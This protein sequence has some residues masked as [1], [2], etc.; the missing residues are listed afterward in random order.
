MSEEMKQV[1]NVAENLPQVDLMVA[2]F[3]AAIASVGGLV[4][5]LQKIVNGQKEFKP[6]TMMFWL[7]LLIEIFTSAFI[8]VLVYWFCSGYELSPYYIAGLA[9][10]AG[11]YGAT[12]FDLIGKVIMKRAGLKNG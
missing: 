3:Y 8:G 11:H 6:K 12:I 9:G 1:A 4:K 10:V 7:A 5:Y 2:L